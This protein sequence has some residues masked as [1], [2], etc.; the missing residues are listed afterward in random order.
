MAATKKVP[1]ENTSPASKQRSSTGYTHT[2]AIG[3]G[4]AVVV[5]TIGYVLLRGYGLSTPLFTSD[6]TTAQTNTVLSG[7]SS[8][9]SKPEIHLTRESVD[10]L[11]DTLDQATRRKNVDGVLQHFAPDATITIHMKQGAQQQ[12]ATLTREEYRKTLAHGICFPQRK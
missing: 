9:P 12:I 7:P 4:L 11:F 6:S 5:A 10:L 2:V 1:A 3:I 8:E